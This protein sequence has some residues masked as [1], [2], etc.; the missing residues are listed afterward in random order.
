MPQL[1]GKDIHAI[2][3][4][5][6]YSVPQGDE[7][8]IKQVEITIVYTAGVHQSWEAGCQGTMSCIG[9]KNDTHVTPAF[10]EE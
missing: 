10:T 2:R 7:G 9:F 6:E 1:D 3:Y 5:L 4:A 8:F